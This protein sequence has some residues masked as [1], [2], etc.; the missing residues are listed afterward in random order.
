MEHLWKKRDYE[1]C[2]D[3]MKEWLQIY[4]CIISSLIPN[5]YSYSYSYTL[6]LHHQKT[7]LDTPTSRRHLACPT[8]CHRNHR[9]KAHPALVR[10][11]L[12]DLHGPIS[13]FCCP[14]TPQI[15]TLSPNQFEKCFQ[16]KQRCARYSLHLYQ[17]Q[18]K[19]MIG[20]LSVLIAN[21]MENRKN[22]YSRF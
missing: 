4:Y 9:R 19:P 2:Y 1:L 21:K 18:P 3:F 15:W 10:R 20:Q 7:S 17:A 14:S 22:V 13:E 11:T 8:N 16:W 6:L 12:S 5:Q